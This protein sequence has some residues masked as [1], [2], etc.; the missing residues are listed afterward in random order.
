MWHNS[1]VTD[2]IAEVMKVTNH[3]ELWYVD[4][5][6]YSPIGTYWIWLNG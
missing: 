5:A 3:I 2:A 1:V 6:W 4:L